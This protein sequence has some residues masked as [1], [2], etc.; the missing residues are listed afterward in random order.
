MAS[1]STLP[2]PRTGRSRPR[3]VRP[4]VMTVER[5]AI[6]GQRMNYMARAHDALRAYGAA[7]QLVIQLGPDAIHFEIHR[8][9][10]DGRQAL[11]ELLAELRADAGCL[12]GKCED[13]IHRHPGHGQGA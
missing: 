12:D 7:Q 2:V 5:H 1:V 13:P 3:I 8:A 11:H 9:L 4:E 6:V 10:R